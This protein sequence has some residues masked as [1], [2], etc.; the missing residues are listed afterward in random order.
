M[1]LTPRNGAEIPC[2][3]LRGY[4]IAWTLSDPKGKATAQGNL[5]LPDLAPGSPP[6]TG[7]IPGAETA[8]TVTAS[9]ITPTGYDVDDARN[10][11]SRPN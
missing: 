11:A 2:Y 10:P 4:H 9:L 7:P 5:A 1:L 8:A 6:W 3:T